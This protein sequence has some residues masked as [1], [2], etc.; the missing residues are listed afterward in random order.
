MGFALC[1]EQPQVGL[2]S[3]HLPEEETEAR[4]DSVTGSATPPGISRAIE[5][6]HAEGPALGPVAGGSQ[7]SPASPSGGPCLVPASLPEPGPG[8]V[9]WGPK[10][11]LHPQQAQL[12]QSI[13]QA[14][15]RCPQGAKGPG[16]AEERD[17]CV[18]VRPLPR[19]PASHYLLYPYYVPGPGGHGPCL[20]GASR[21][22]PRGPGA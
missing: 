6:V 9:C 4:R 19:K 15:G 2:S 22:D 20:P 5:G 17:R 18:E 10:R 13:W 16:T 7:D 3:P 1:S 12:L 21:S 11:A 8:E 14:V